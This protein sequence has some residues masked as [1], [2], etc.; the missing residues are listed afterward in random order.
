MRLLGLTRA[1]VR[2]YRDEVRRGDRSA[3]P[4]AVRAS[5]GLGTSQSDI[6]RLLGAVAR[7]AD[8]GPPP[9]PYCQDRRTGD[10]HPCRDIPGLTDQPG[11][12]AAPCSPG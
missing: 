1:E 10:F 12:H 8:G 6:E 7:I 11:A 5:A 4:G 3:M 9:V 2:R